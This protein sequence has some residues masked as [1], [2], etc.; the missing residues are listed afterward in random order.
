MLLMWVCDVDSVTAPNG[1]FMYRSK[2]H[3]GMTQE[4]LRIFN[5]STLMASLKGT[6]IP[7]LGDTFNFSLSRNTAHGVISAG[8]VPPG[9]KI[10]VADSA[11]HRASEEWAGHLYLPTKLPE[12]GDNLSV[13]LFEFFCVFS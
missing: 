10:G 12:S 9:T 5:T 11:Y 2:L 3:G 1:L 13:G 6:E 7:A 4:V 8:G